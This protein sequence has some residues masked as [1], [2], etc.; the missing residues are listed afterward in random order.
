MGLVF[1]LLIVRLREICEAVIANLGNKNKLFFHLL[2][3]LPFTVVQQFNNTVM[4]NTYSCMIKYHSFSVNKIFERHL[5]NKDALCANNKSGR[6]YSYCC[7]ILQ[8][9]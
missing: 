9:L 7:F 5:Q 4:E 6:Y 1:Q 2:F 8:S 3:S